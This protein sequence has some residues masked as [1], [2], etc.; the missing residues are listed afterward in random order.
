MSGTPRRNAPVGAG[1]LFDV[2]RFALH[3]GPGIRTTAFFKGCPL[4]CTW[5]HNPE[6]Q[7]SSPELLHRPGLCVGCGACLSVCPKDAI[8]IVAGKA[9]TD[10]DRCTACGACVPVCS[11][12]ARSIVGSMW[13]AEDLVDELA[14]DTVFYEQSGGGITCSGGEP[15]QQARF[16]AEVLRRC[17]QMSIHTA[18][19]TCGYADASSLEHVAEHTDLFLYDLKLMDDRRHRQATGVSNHVVLRNLQR[20]N[21]WG[22]SVWIRV[23]LAPGIN[24]DDGN[25]LTLAGFIRGLTCVEALQLLPY[26]AGGETKWLG[27]GRTGIG[28]PR[29]NAT[30]SSA[31]ADR[32]V[33]MLTQCLDVPVARG[34]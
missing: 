17:R 11:H 25:L 7:S 12:D 8:R 14:K 1:I 33:R 6:S 29:I 32:A 5:C 24:D 10:R 3:D 22:C 19:D 31:A 23:P 15:L 13:S 18:V 27:L 28:R 26:H 2:K 30:A 21:R 4:S 34:G 9:V 16:C 20:L